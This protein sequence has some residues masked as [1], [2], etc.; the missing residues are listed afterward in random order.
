M[1]DVD[2]LHAT[3]SD[4]DQ[5]TSAVDAD[6]ED[7]DVSE[8]GHHL[9]GHRKK[10][11][12]KMKRRPARQTD[13]S[14][15]DSDS[16]I[17][18]PPHNQKKVNPHKQSGDA[19][20]AEDHMHDIREGSS[21]DDTSSAGGSTPAS[22]APASS[23][24]SKSQEAVKS[25]PLPVDKLQEIQRAMQLLGVPQGAPKNWEEAS[26]KSYQF[27]DTQPVPKLGDKVTE[28]RAIEE[29]RP[30]EEIR[31]ECYSLPAGFTWDTLDIT[32]PSILKELYTLLN[33]N[34]VEDD[35]NMFR[36][37]YSPE[38]LQWALQPPGW[39]KEWHCG[40]R[41]I[42]S[43]KL[44]GFISAVPA[45]IKIYG[46]DRKMVEINFLCVHKKLRSK[47]V[48]PVL[49]REITRRVHMQGLFQAVYTAGVVLPKPVG[50][51]R[52]WHRSLNPRKLIEV[53]FSHLSRN[54]T[55]QRTLKLYKLPDSPKTKGF[56][57]FTPADVGDAFKLMVKYLTRFDLAPVFSEEEFRHW[58]IPRTNI[59]DSYVVENN[60]VITDFVS[61]YTLPST[62]MHHSSHKFLKAAYS[63]YNVSTKTPWVD[64]M[65]DALIVAKNMGF[66]V[67]NALDLMENKEF[68]EKLKFGIGD[69]NL[70]YYLYNWMCPSMNSEQVGLVLQ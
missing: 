18:D 57:P 52:Y 45:E 46:V 19:Y 10:S 12:Q 61:F 26:R 59:I 4:L 47:R 3:D 43:K 2:S 36:F 5:D 69:G 32:S 17:I 49:I 39:L 62:V 65:Q 44:V 30:V 1:A 41:V 58:F 56:R 50:T 31:Q 66:D 70:Q 27:W 63:F 13:P 8:E 14:S 34:Y 60:G 64:L 21:R 7:D 42:K 53:K 28:N 29:D 23:S 11:K 37:D 67:F 51:C 9:E 33:E 16:Q 6:G 54:M 35:D 25:P 68:L 40:V 24:A 55:M 48:A 22:N 38:F 15:G 20:P